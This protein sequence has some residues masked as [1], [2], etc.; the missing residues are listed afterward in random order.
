MENK[1]SDRDKI[2][3]LYKFI[4]E[5]WASRQKHI[6]NDDEYE[7]KLQVNKIP[8]DKENISFFYQDVIEDEDSEE[9]VPANNV[10]LKVHKPE[11]EKCPEPDVEISS[12]IEDDWKDYRKRI[13]LKEP[14]N[15][16]ENVDLFEYDINVINQFNNWIEKRDE[17]RNKQLLI[18]QTRNLFTD[19]YTKYVDLQRDSEIKELIVSNGYIK[20]KNNSKLNHGVLTKRLSINFD[21]NDN[22]IYIIDTNSKPE[23]YTDMFHQIED[24]NRELLAELQDDLDKNEY[25]PL[26]RNDSK[27][28]F[29]ILIHK[30]SSDGRFIDK[31][32]D[33]ENDNSRFQMFFSPTFNLLHMHL[34]F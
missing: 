16:N 20:D 8:N 6:I 3:A 27:D 15:N 10:I 25:H 19:L 13:N 14:I 23:L 28:F 7:W 22:T 29:K 26:D 30:I 9:E 18:E 2:S 1:F 33:L 31:P 17:W 32:E 12:L 11:F 21:A 4:K 5:Y 34:S 24:I